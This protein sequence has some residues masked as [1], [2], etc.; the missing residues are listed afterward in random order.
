MLLLFFVCGESRNVAP[1]LS[2]AALTQASKRVP[3]HKENRLPWCAPETPVFADVVI[4]CWRCF[5][6]LAMLYCIGCA[7]LFWLCFIVRAVRPCNGGISFEPYLSPCPPSLH[8]YK[9]T[10]QRRQ[11]FLLRPLKRRPQLRPHIRPV[12][13]LLHPLHPTSLPPMP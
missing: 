8:P 12:L 6:V 7:S 2:V 1:I 13:L 10:S 11:L 5:F 4:L 3:H 9:S